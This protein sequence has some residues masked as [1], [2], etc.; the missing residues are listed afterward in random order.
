[1]SGSEESDGDDEDEENSN[2]GEVV[3]PSTSAFVIAAR[4][5]W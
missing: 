3:G 1:M 5:I 4:L 2:G